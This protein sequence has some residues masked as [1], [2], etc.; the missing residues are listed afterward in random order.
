MEQ[1]ENHII[2]DYKNKKIGNLEQ[3][4]LVYTGYE[5]NLMFFPIELL[6]IVFETAN[7]MKNR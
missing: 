1:N 3:Y 6:K 4:K 7:T 2:C 5:E